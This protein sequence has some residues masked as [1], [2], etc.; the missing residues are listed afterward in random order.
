LRLSTYKALVAYARKAG[1][2]AELDVVGENQLA[3]SHG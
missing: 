1:L 3:E 2:D